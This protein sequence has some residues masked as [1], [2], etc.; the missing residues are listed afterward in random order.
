[1][2]TQSSE[3]AVPSIG[4]LFPSVPH[5]YLPG[6]CLQHLI[7]ENLKHYTEIRTPNSHSGG[8]IMLSPCLIFTQNSEHHATGHHLQLIHLLPFLWDVNSIRGKNGCVVFAGFP[9]PKSSSHSRHSVTIVCTKSC[10]VSASSLT[11]KE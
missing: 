6:V 7:S 10:H 4:R 5:V 1:M 3:L 9:T 2:W 11:I 8:H